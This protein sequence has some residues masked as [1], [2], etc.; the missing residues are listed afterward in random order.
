LQE[1]VD[2]IMN[3]NRMGRGNLIMFASCIKKG[4]SNIR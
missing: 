2:R 3:D 1:I 4:R